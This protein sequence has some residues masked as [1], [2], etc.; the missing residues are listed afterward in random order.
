VEPLGARARSAAQ[1]AH[2]FSFCIISKLHFLKLSAASISMVPSLLSV[3]T[4]S[5]SSKVFL[6]GAIVTFAI[7]LYTFSSSYSF[8]ISDWSS[9]FSQQPHH[10]LCSPEQ[11]SSGRWVYSPTSD[12]VNLTSPEQ[13][14]SLAGFEGCAADR[15]YHWHL[16]TD[17]EE[18]WDRFPKVSSY[19]WLPSS[20]CDVRPL[21][22]A[23][24]VKDLVENG[25]WLL[26][27]GMSV[28]TFGVR[29]SSIS[30]LH[31]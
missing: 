3:R 7:T 20:Q 5:L 23:A 6:L 27:G 29:L 16:G 12:L 26:L 17:H 1:N 18:F 30:F 31:F 10:S 15:E 9:I 14:L 13:A 28:L 4:R 8:R 11:W 25:G 2:K 24:I 22:G 19:R 21:D